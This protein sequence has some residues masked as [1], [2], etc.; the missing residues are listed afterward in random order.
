MR[1][2]TYGGTKQL[3]N[4]LKYSDDSFIAIT[5]WLLFWISLFETLV[6]PIT[7]PLSFILK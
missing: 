3:W 2:L 5:L 7:I 6:L 4:D 1:N